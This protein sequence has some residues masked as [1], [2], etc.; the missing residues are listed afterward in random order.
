M[1]RLISG[2]L[3]VCLMAA[4]LCSGAAAEGV[5]P[6]KAGICNVTPVTSIEGVTVSFEAFNVGTSVQASGNSYVDDK[7]VAMANFYPEADNI[8]VTLTG[9]ASGSFVLALCTDE[10]ITAP[11][12][13]SDE[14]LYIDQNTAGDDVFFKVYPEKLEAGTTYYVYGISNSDDL[15]TLTK[16]LSFTAFA[17]YKLGDPDNDGQITVADASL[18]LQYL[19]SSPE[20]KQQLIPASL[21]PAADADKDGQITVADASLILQYLVSSP[22]VK[23]QLIPG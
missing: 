1:K 16:V 21:E 3:L 15:K 13:E 20:V 6:D 7:G 22:E 5:Q 19:V 2:V 9:I 4:L 14:I 23:Q 11:P 18:I 17:P 10:E 8:K 12:N